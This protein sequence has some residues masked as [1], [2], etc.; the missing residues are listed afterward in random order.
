MKEQKVMHPLLG[1]L[2]LIPM[3]APFLSE[4]RLI[5]AINIFQE[6]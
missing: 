2:P 3:A 5:M 6:E 1:P 4:G